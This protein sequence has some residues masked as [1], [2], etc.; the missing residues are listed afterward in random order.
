[1]SVVNTLT[2][3][4]ANNQLSI[5][6]NSFGQVVIVNEIPVYTGSD[7]GGIDR[8]LVAPQPGDVTQ[9]YEF[10]ATY[11]NLVM[12]AGVNLNPTVNING[13]T[14]YNLTANV[15]AI[16]AG[17]GIDVG[18]GSSTNSKLISTKIV[19]F[20]G[21]PSGSPGNPPYGITFSTP[22]TNG[23]VT[24]TPTVCGITPGVGIG[25]ANV[26]LSQ[27]NTLQ[28]RATVA[29][30]TEGN[31]I[32]VLS[33]PL[34]GNYQ[35][36]ATVGDI[37]PGDGIFITYGQGG[38]YELGVNFDQP[39]ASGIQ[40]QINDE[41]NFELDATY[42][43]LNGI[44]I[45]VNRSAGDTVT[46]P[47]ATLVANVA[48]ITT[49]PQ[50]GISATQNQTTNEWTL[51]NTGILAVQGDPSI[52]VTTTNGVASLSYNPT[53]TFGDDLTLSG[54]IQVPVI[55]GGR[56]QGSHFATYTLP[57][58]TALGS[59][60]SI[61]GIQH[62]T[63]GQ[64]QFYMTVNNLDGGLA[65]GATVYLVNSINGEKTLLFAEGGLIFEGF[66]Y[67]TQNQQSGINADWGY[68][69]SYIFNLRLNINGVFQTFKCAGLQVSQPYEGAIPFRA[70][71][72]DTPL[73]A[74]GIAYNGLNGYSIITTPG[75]G[76]YIGA[77]LTSIVAYI[78]CYPLVDIG[79]Y[80]NPVITRQYNRLNDNLANASRGR[81]FCTQES[82]GL[83]EIPLSQEAPY[84]GAP[85]AI[86][87][88]PV[89]TGWL[90]LTIVPLEDQWTVPTGTIPT[91]K[92][93]YLVYLSNGQS[94]SVY[95]TLTQQW[96]TLPVTGYVSSFYNSQVTSVAPPNDSIYSQFYGGGFI[97][98]D[99]AEDSQGNF[100]T[101]TSRA[102]TASLLF[103]PPLNYNDCNMFI[104]YDRFVPTTGA[105][106]AFANVYQSTFQS[107]A[108]EYIGNSIQIKALEYLQLQTN[109]DCEVNS[110]S[111][112]L[113]NQA[114]TLNSGVVDFFTDS[115]SVNTGSV[116]IQEGVSVN[117]DGSTL[118]IS[119]TTV[120]ADST[121]IIDFRNASL[122]VQPKL[123]QRLY[124][125]APDPFPPLRPPFLMKVPIVQSWRIPLTQLPGIQPNVWSIIQI[126]PPYT[127]DLDFLGSITMTLVGDPVANIQSPTL[128]MTS[129]LQYNIFATASTPQQFHAS[130]LYTPGTGNQAMVNPSIAFTMIQNTQTFNP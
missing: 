124:I 68:V 71:G 3:S 84:F 51:S 74:S 81:C 88:S 52:T 77:P 92:F 65:T 48:S 85:V 78:N 34:T 39:T 30:I 130:V 102:Q 19:G 44:G 79:Q 26:N 97:K 45:N 64:G 10:Q 25:V 89:G 18:V 120:T 37:L 63:T 57:Q 29:D 24:V 7:S 106:V 17:P 59:T 40:Q 116:D 33:D 41:G 5:Q 8:I 113:T 125:P 96:Q 20:T 98:S 86:P 13:D 91:T 126:Q 61:S 6:G 43:N 75:F 70:V 73:T 103:A 55:V 4:P 69:C 28:V 118:S 76:I 67:L 123:V 72:G 35:V 46:P 58:N 60:Y 128:V 14:E 1:M 99:L 127:L 11:E 93:N 90:P 80:G 36:S 87:N 107:D 101:F 15:A 62:S 112:E 114:M 49:S 16:E 66:T 94:S 47:S 105:P 54:S 2:L 95:N 12:G 82:G 111:L 129:T 53:S 119:N 122:E 56:T 21:P 108:A 50:G 121:S 32:T 42:A 31:G 109:G 22:D 83:I 104:S 38:T 117:I 23:I 115:L 27:P 110:L 9:H 100:P